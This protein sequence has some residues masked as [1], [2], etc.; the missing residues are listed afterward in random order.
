[1][2]RYAITGGTG[3][4]GRAVARELR[5]SGHEAVPLSRRAGTAVDDVDGLTRAF[6][7]CDGVIHCAGINR[8]LRGQ[9]YAQVHVAGTRN[10]VDAARRAGV[11]KLV[12]MSFL[13][14]R[15]DCGSGYHESKW[16]AEELV[17]ASGLDFTVIK[18]GVVFG[19]GD[20]M[21]DHLTRSLLTLPLFGLVG[22]RPR[23][24]RPAA[25]EDVARVLCAALTDRRLRN[26]TFPVTG[27]RELLLGDAVRIVA[28]EIGRK[29]LLFRLP[30]M[31]HRALAFGLERTMRV[32]LIA[33][34]QVRILSESLVEATGVVDE[35]P[36]DLQPR[37]AFDR[38]AIRT[39]LPRLE[40]FGFSDLELSACPHR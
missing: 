13:R 31:I 11:R 16:A 1:M 5:A 14:A 3:F 8:E 19:K 23:P 36:P 30:V 2:T 6:A 25:V 20:H 12:M 38:A 18:A 37:I 24:M 29:P 4:V 9:S 35:L 22:L 17:R 28:D 34:A 40:R 32:P 26:G 39:R 21:L 10:V 33:L 7:D 27:P 15:P